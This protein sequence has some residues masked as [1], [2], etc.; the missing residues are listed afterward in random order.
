MYFNKDIQLHTNYV[1]LYTK[2]YIKRKKK[3][4]QQKKKKKDRGI[5]KRSTLYIVK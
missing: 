3:E 4:K 1:Q 5:I 2:I